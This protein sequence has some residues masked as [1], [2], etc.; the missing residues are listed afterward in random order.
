MQNFNLEVLKNEAVSRSGRNNGGNCR[1]NEKRLKKDKSIIPSVKMAY[2]K[3]IAVS[4]QFTKDLYPHSLNFY[5]FEVFLYDWLVVIINPIEGKRVVIVNDSLALHC[6]Y[7][8]HKNEIFVG[9]NSRNYDSAIFKGILLD[10]DPKDINDDIILDGRKPF[11]I[12]E[13]FRKMKLL[14][15]D[16]FTERGLKTLEGFM[17]NDIRESTIPF[18]LPRPLTTSEIH[19]TI[20]YCRHDVEQTIE[21]F[22]RRKADYDAQIDLIDTFDLSL[23]SISLTKAQLTA[24]IIGCQRLEHHDEFNLMFV[25]TL[26][27]SKYREVLDWFKNPENMDYRK[28]LN[29]NVCGIPHQ[30]GWGGLHGYPVEPIYRKGR[31]YHVDVTSYYPSMMIEYDFL[32]R[33][34][35]EK[36]KYKR[37]YDTRV[38][39]KKA[40]KKK[41]QAPYKIIL[42][43]T[44]GIMKDKNS[45]AYDPLMANNVSVNGQLML[46]DLLEHLEPCAEIL[47][48]NTDGIILM[49]DDSDAAEAKMKEVCAEW[50]K[51]TKMGL[52]FDEITEIWQKDVNNYVFRFKNGKL[53]RKGAYVK[54]PSELDYDLTVI[55]TAMIDYLTQGIPVETT[56]KNCKKL[57]DFQKIVKV[58]SN[59]AVGFHNGK[60]LTD[61]TY[62]VFASNNP[63]DGFVGR[64]KTVDSTPEKFANTPEHAF[65][66]NESVNDKPIPANLDYKWYIDLANE[67]LVQ[68]GIEVKRKG[69]LF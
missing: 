19:E 6:Y 42:N 15:Y 10:L 36:E 56:I 27:I 51:R 67:R 58:S 40:G 47:Q 35:S 20:K 13:R 8:N 21:V 50:M 60:M 11:E 37:I 34:C 45:K 1:K 44:Y 23:E 2:T 62:R 38:A 63:H 64:A 5:D 41:E 31:I 49:I 24:N 28:S 17:G 48:S 52:G 25:P 12:D 33:N 26:K 66:M 46:L 29:V 18:D 32:T 3:D 7:E 65:I 68:F 53:E 61:K 69:S 43:A 14:N 30:F 39:L 9:Y 4:D 55:N 59:Y 16:L 54:E 22:K 57:I